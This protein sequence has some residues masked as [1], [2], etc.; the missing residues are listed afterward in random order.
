[1]KLL[2]TQ[3]PLEELCT[4]ATIIISSNACVKN[5]LGVGNRVLSLGN[6]QCG[7]NTIY[8]GSCLEIPDV[9]WQ[10]HKKLELPS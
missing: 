8:A 7:V 2:D 1:M 4:L 3:L 10:N 9:T 6:K 5:H